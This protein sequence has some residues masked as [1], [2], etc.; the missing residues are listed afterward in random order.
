MKKQ[1]ISWNTFPLIDWDILEHFMNK[2]S[3]A[4][5]LWYTKHC[6]NF[7]DIGKMMKRMKLW[8]TDLCPCCQQIP[9]SNTTH[10][11]I[12]PHPLIAN[13]RESSFKEI[14]TWMENSNTDP[15][16]YHLL[17]PLWYRKQPIFKEEETLELVKIWDIL[18]DIGTAS[19]WMGL[20][21]INLC[22]L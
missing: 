14:L 19:T 13:K 1:L 12:C 10:L 21:P 6:T 18:Q 8:T 7:C 2:Q 3:R 20:F 22:D 16:I 4:F 17:Y 9:E 15:S 5:K 11:Y